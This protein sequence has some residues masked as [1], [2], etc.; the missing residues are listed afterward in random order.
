MIGG[1]L[2]RPADAFPDL[3]GN[4]DFLKKY[5]Y[6]LPCAVA[7]SFTG[8]VWVITFVFLKETLTNPQSLSEFLGFRASPSAHLITP[9][10]QDKEK[11]LP[12]RAMMT[13][14]VLISASNYATLSLVDIAYR[15][16]L[17]LFLSTPILLGGLGLPPP[18]IGKIL[19]FL[20]TFNGFFQ[21]FFFAKLHDRWG[22]KRV[23]IGGLACSLPVFALFPVINLMA[24]C[25]GYSTSLWVVIG[26]QTMTFAAVNS[27]FGEPSSAK[28]PGSS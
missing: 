16:I 23:F 21:V 20:G 9:Q 25:Q 19:A 10:T 3:F 24:R 12:L 17:P 28:I 14:N 22:T 18:A 26:L 2:A 8:F 4:S 11:P 6:F 13:Y 15:A 7:A 5:P 27:A 1:T